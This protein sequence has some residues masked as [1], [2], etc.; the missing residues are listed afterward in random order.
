MYLLNYIL[1]HYFCD[2]LDLLMD[3]AT[4]HKKKLVYDL[5]SEFGK[6]RI[7]P[8]IWVGDWNPSNAKVRRY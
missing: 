6:D 2:R 3:F 8:S 7:G 1:I 5:S 4:K